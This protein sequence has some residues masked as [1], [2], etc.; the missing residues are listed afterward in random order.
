MGARAGCGLPDYNSNTLRQTGAT[1]R[2]RSFVV[3]LVA[4]CAAG[5]FAQEQKAAP[6]VA[7]P[8]QTPKFSLPQ[9]RPHVF[10]VPPELAGKS[11]ARLP[12]NDNLCYSMSTYVFARQGPGDATQLVAHR[13]CT[14]A[15]LF[16]L[17]EAPA[18][19][20]GR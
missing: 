9:N 10:V 4:M 20:S 1:M 11:R 14:R 16:R 17:K 5:A 13:D 8:T 2:Y 15:S 6:P 18:K 12:V 7:P 3:L 19:P